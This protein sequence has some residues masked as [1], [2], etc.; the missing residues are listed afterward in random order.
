MRS[1]AITNIAAGGVVESLAMKATG[2]K[3]VEAYRGY[4]GNS[5][6]QRM[7]VAEIGSIGG[8]KRS[9]GVVLSQRFIHPDGVNNRNSLSDM[10]M[11]QRNEENILQI[12]NATQQ[13]TN[14]YSSPNKRVK[15]VHNHFNGAVFHFADGSAFTK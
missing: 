3:S 10:T 12:N 14:L 6:A 11:M 9:N 1:T 8:E 4:V 7:A 2:H 13:N 15:I 5:N